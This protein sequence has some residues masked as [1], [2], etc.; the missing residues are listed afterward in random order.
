MNPFLDKAHLFNCE[1]VTGKLVLA[2]L[3]VDDRQVLRDI[4]D[5]LRDKLDS[6]VLVVVGKGAESH[7]IIV[8]VSR[9]LTKSIHA[10]KLL[11][12]MMAQTGGKGGGRPDSAQGAVSNQTQLIKMFKAAKDS[13]G[14]SLD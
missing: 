2:N 10:R 13:L 1:G 9:D 12:E 4:S 14:I 11:K 6:G 5:Q 3:D 8:N 7:P